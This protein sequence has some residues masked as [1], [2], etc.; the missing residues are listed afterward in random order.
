MRKPKINF[1]EIVAVCNVFSEFI[2]TYID[3]FFCNWYWKEIDD[4]ENFI[5]F[6]ITKM[7]SIQEMPKGWIGHI[8][9]DYAFW[10]VFGRDA[11][12]N[13]VLKR[14][15]LNLNEINSHILNEFIETPVFYM[16]FAVE[17][18]YKNHFLLIRDLE[19]NE[20]ELLYSRG[21]SMMRKE[22]KL[23]FICLV[24][25]NG[26]CYQTYGLIHGFRYL[27]PYDL[28]FYASL[29][30][31]LYDDEEY[32]LDFISK[33]ARYI[34]FLD[35]KS[36]I[37]AQGTK[38]NH[39]IHISWSVHKVLDF[40]PALDDKKWNIS[41]IK[42]KLILKPKFAIDQP[43]DIYY[44]RNKKRLIIHAITEEDHDLILNKLSSYFKLKTN[45]SWS[46]SPQ[47]YFLAQELF[48]Y[49]LP[50]DKYRID[51]QNL[52]SLQTEEILLTDP[53][54]AD[55]DDIDNNFNQACKILI[56]AF[57]Y[58]DHVD[59]EKLS[60]QVNIPVNE[61]QE[62]NQWISKKNE[63]PFKDLEGGIPD[64]EPI[65]PIMRTVIFQ[66]LWKKSF[67]KENKTAMKKIEKNIIEAFPDIPS[68]METLYDKIDYI[69]SNQKGIIAEHSSLLSLLFYMLVKNQNEFHKCSEYAV[70]ILKYM[71]H[72]LYK[73]FSKSNVTRFITL[74][75]KQLI[76]EFLI[77]AKLVDTKATSFKPEETEKM[78]NN[79]QYEMKA[80]T[81]LLKSIKL[82][83]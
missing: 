37:P 61:L 69:F 20:P 26:I 53:N 17:E 51:D 70:E 35:T 44:I 29:L 67:F 27:S 81:L 10:R 34:Y 25:Y 57:N 36:E 38:K 79:G 48:D 62:I 13:D 40:N 60:N 21:V 63:T 80:N 71:G 22:D 56:H 39:I 72:I 5:S 78:L 24:F 12:V 58:G 2:R 6:M 3:E 64:F 30:P 73:T 28:H 49:E 54:T 55:T 83:V 52:S 59:F 9:N 18:D 15:K 4:T 41:E 14:Y 74:F 42:S 11:L 50:I 31:G 66:P 47:I 32:P 45:E 8:L 77:P 43:V 23:F 65:P 75:S 46:I 33:D 76:L 82:T 19:T 7:P 16:L 1:D 68:Q